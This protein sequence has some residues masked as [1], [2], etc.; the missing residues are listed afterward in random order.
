[1]TLVSEYNGCIQMQLMDNY[2]MLEEGFQQQAYLDYI[3]ISSHDQLA[4][5]HLEVKYAIRHID[6]LH[7]I[8]N[9]TERYYWYFYVKTRLVAML[10]IVGMDFESCSAYGFDTCTYK[11]E[12]VTK[13]HIN[14]YFLEVWNKKY[15]LC[16][17]V[18]SHMSPYRLVANVFVVPFS[19]RW[20]DVLLSNVCKPDLQ[21]YKV[22]ASKIYAHDLDLYIST[23]A[24]DYLRAL[25]Y[26]PECTCD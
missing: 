2:R 19:K 25:K 8:G 15:I 17:S 20:W 23:S 3:R 6:Y 22:Y 4:V 5:S 21:N 12:Y 24:T 1:M 10:N 13:L 14:E 16:P 26:L 11:G 18:S 9:D 7:K